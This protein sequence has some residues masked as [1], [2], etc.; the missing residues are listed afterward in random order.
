MIYHSIQRCKQTNKQTNKHKEVVAARTC[1][2]LFA[3]AC[4]L[5]RF[6]FDLLMSVSA[7][8]DYQDDN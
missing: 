3:F 8:A 5:M 4:T 2:L 7:G 6:T 1:E